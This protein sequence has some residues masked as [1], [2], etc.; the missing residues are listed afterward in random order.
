MFVSEQRHQNAKKHVWRIEKNGIVT[1][2]TQFSEQTEYFQ[3]II[4][5]GL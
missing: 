4:T 1:N 2:Y 5:E 3:V